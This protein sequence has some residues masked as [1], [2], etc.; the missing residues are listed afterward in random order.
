MQITHYLNFTKSQFRTRISLETYQVLS[1]NRVTSISKNEYSQFHAF[2][3][4]FFADFGCNSIRTG[5]LN[6]LF[7]RES[8]L[9][10]QFQITFGLSSVSENGV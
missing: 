3:M 9:E 7:L 10:R 6:L 2:M 1:S 8:R 4:S 5:F